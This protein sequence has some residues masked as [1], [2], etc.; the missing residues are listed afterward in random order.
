MTKKKGIIAT[1][2]LLVVASLA[3]I[4]YGH[5]MAPTRILIV[6]ALKAQQAD[7]GLQK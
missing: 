6:N 5:W 1:L 4:G 3:Y 2:A 7:F